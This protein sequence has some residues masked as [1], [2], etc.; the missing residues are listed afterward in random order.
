MILMTQSKAITAV[1]LSA[2]PAISVAS[3]TLVYGNSSAWTVHTDPGHGYRC[4]AE[5]EYVGG[6]F[7]RIGYESIESADLYLAI[8][9]SAWRDIAEGQHY[10]LTL[11]FDEQESSTVT[12]IGLDSRD[13]FSIAIP[14]TERTSFLESF[15]RG[16]SISVARSGQEPVMLG[17]GGTFGA[18]NML[19]E[20]QSEM[21]KM[22]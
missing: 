18:V 14:A 15:K 12:A 2:I 19:A 20:C 16:Y 4:F 6:S 22:S 8:G 10:D 3:G 9:D 7:M 1:L 5:A 17:L 11:Q 21:S 13:G